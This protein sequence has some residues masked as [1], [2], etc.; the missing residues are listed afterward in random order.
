MRRELW[1]GALVAALLGSGRGFGAEPSCCEPPQDCFLKRIGPVGGWFPDAGGL[2]NWWPE[3]CFPRCGGPDDYC[4]KPIPCV[5]WPPYPP[6]FIWRPAGSCCPNPP[7]A[8]HGLD[9]Q[10]AGLNGP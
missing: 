8:G 4:R 2:L 3:C 6:Y 10:H 7:E 1:I 5:C 9:A